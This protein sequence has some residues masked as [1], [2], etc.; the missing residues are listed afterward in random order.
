[1]EVQGGQPT[2]RRLFAPLLMLLVLVLLAYFLRLHN[3]DAFSFW[4]D[5]GLTPERSGYPVAQIL[6]NEILIQGFVT[7]D[8]HPPLYYLV[9][10]VTRSLFGETDFAFRYPSV[11]FGVLL[12]PLIY[13][14][15]RRMGDRTLGLI[16]ALL[17]AVNPLQVYYSQEAR[18]YTLLV[19]LVT[20]MSY[21]LWRSIETTDHGRRT[22]HVLPSSSMVCRPSF[23]FRYLLLYIA[24]AA[25]AF[26]THYTVAF[27][28]AV[29][30]LFWAWLL[31]RAGLRWLIL[32]AAGLGL[33]L[34]IPLVPYTVPRLFS[35]AEANYAYVSPLTMLQDVVH[36]FNLGLTTD[37]DQFF[38]KALDIIALGTLLLG[39]WAA[40]PWLKR[41]FLLSWLLA[42]VLGLMVGSILFKPM[43][44]GVRHIMASSPAFLLLVGFG[45]WAAWTWLP[46]SWRRDPS[47]RTPI[48]E[49][50]DEL[51]GWSDWVAASPRFN[52]LALVL[53]GLL[54]I[55]PA[56]ALVNLYENPAYV[57]DDFRAIIRYIEDTAGERDTIVY[58]NA[59]LLPLH[60]HYRTRS[61][62]DVTALPVYPQFASGAEPELTALAR[63]Y[64]RI[65]F[66]TDPPADRR[67]EDKLIQGWFEDNL[68]TVSNRLFPARTT[69]ARVITYATADPQPETPPDD[70]HLL[71][72]AWDGLPE[73]RG[74]AIGSIQPLIR[75]SLWVD[76]FWRG[77]RPPDNTRLRFGLA[78]ADGREYAAEDFRL[79]GRERTLWDDATFNRRS[80]DI[81]LP[82]GLPPGTYTLQVAPDGGPAADLAEVTVAATPA[83]GRGRPAIAWENGLALQGIEL[84]DDTVLPGNNLPLT[85]VWR[86]GTTGLDLSESRYR[87]EVIAP[88]GETLRVQEDKPGAPWLGEVPPATVLR[89]QT[90]LYFR[91]ETPPGD[92]RLRWTLLDGAATVGRPVVEGRLTVEAWP[93]VTE[94]PAAQTLLEA[95]LGPAIRF[96]GFDR[97]EIT[98]GALPLTLYWQAAA[99]PGGDYSVFIHLVDEATGETVAQVDGIPVQ[100]LRLTSGWRAGEVLTDPY[101]LPVPAELPAGRYAIYAG[102]YRSEDGVRLPVS[103]DGETQPGDR[104]RLLTLELPEVIP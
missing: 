28:I 58:N 92:Y 40:R 99:A 11:L 98:D 87:L 64:D 49:E 60:E 44:Q 7:K 30:A 45:V 65:W 67:D 101:R 59:V 15:A 4:T 31:W 47:D 69:E 82:A 43:Y 84:W 86:T 2:G 78:G 71:E 50:T 16:V 76:L 51:T 22:M 93:L 75:P 85:L 20:G 37:F 80:Y 21:V 33:L 54:L 19:L 10:H 39:L 1:M 35:G 56:L 68:P 79:L 62:I 88:D 12:I 52:P 23:L 83:T 38:I 6:R 53:L 57:K 24:L 26:Y 46:A 8:T 103:L 9:I 100:G 74:V 25:L 81:S 63:D 77:E 55:G 70:A 29:Q 61:D 94:L 3:L 91:P 36:F 102:L 34:A 17:A 90:G 48:E 97:G 73:L 96:Y 14:L 27:L 5:E 66:I 95:E 41:G 13:Q 18:M 42:V 32:G 89:E 104:L 72:L